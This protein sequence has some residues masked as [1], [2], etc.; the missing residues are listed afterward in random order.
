MV[1]NSDLVTLCQQRNSVAAC[2]NNGT[3]FVPIIASLSFGH[4]GLPIVHGS[5]N[6]DGLDIGLI[7]TDASGSTLSGVDPADVQIGACPGGNAITQAE[8]CPDPT[9]EA[10]QHGV[11]ISVPAGFKS[12]TINN[13]SGIT[14]IDGMFGLG[15]GRR[16]NLITYDASSHQNCFDGRLPAIALAGGTW[17]WTGIL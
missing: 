6:S 15:D 17:Q 14:T 1:A 12:V 4:N 9:T 11:N 10:I 5:T 16:A 7:F 3:D 8:L 2:W 13:L